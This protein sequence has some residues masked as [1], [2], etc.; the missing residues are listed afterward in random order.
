MLAIFRE[1]L[2]F[3]GKC[4]FFYK[5]YCRILNRIIIIIIIIIVI[6]QIKY[7]NSLNNNNNTG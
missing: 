6:M 3:F 1:L 7:H 4:S 5:L 2:R